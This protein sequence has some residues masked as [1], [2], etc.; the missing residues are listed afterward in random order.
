MNFL[1]NKNVWIIL[2][3]VLLLILIFFSSAKIIAYI[4]DGKK[5]DRVYDEI[6]EAYLDNGLETNA[7]DG[8]NTNEDNL[9]YK[10]AEFLLGINKNTAGWISILGTKV[11]YPVLRGDDNIHY[12]KYNLEE[13]RSSRGSIMMDYRNAGDSRDLNITIYGH[14]MKDD[15]MFHDLISY[16]DRAFFELYPKVQFDTLERAGEYSIFSV[17]VADSIEDNIKIN[18]SDE[19]EYS[20]Y[21][22]S[23][24]N[25]SLYDCE[26][27]VNASD[28]ILTLTTCTYEKKGANLIIH[29]KL[30]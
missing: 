9:Y 21:L 19:I 3:I 2:L 20:E 8:L 18:F 16:K 5:T 23:V 25:L 11:D 6:R 29:A 26:I 17:Y 22:E 28:R 24:K 15:S 30:N 10:K 12:L 1:K 7:K 14:N 4:V 27:E 13:K